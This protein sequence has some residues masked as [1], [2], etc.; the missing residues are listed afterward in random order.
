MR[1]IEKWLATIIDKTPNDMKLGAIVRDI[2][3]KEKK[4]KEEDI[5]WKE[6]LNIDDGELKD[7]YKKLP[8]DQKDLLDALME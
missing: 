6:I 4:N 7:W 5:N 2:Y 3:L 1:K 8:N